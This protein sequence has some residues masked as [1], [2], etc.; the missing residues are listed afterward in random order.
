MHKFGHRRGVP[1]WDVR[2][3]IW[4]MAFN[5]Q[6]VWKRRRLGIGAPANFQEAPASR[7]MMLSRFAL[8][9]HKVRIPCQFGLS[10]GRRVP[11]KLISHVG[12][13]LIGKDERIVIS[14]FVIG[15]AYGKV[16]CRIVRSRLPCFHYASYGAIAGKRREAAIKVQL[17]LQQRIHMAGLTSF[18]KLFGAINVFRRSSMT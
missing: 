10:Q 11:K 16:V 9:R 3:E 12:H 13:E 1:S 14:F 8:I 6:W 5:P 15:K 2:A 18:T 7:D 17:I 4:R